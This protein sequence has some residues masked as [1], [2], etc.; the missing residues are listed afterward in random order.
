M[1]HTVLAIDQGTSSTK[2]MVV[3]PERDVLGSA[4]AD[5]RPR[6]GSDGSVEVDPEGMLRSVLDAGRQAVAR[7]GEPRIDAI[8][9]ANQGE[10]VLAWDPA[11]GRPLTPA[12]SWSDRRAASIC[13]EL[14]GMADE[15]RRITGL[16][17]DPYFA[18][19]KM[20]WIR[21]HLTRDGVVTT[22]DAWLVDRL[23]G[24]FV[25]DAATAG[26]TQLLDLDEVAWSPTA[27][28]AFG[29]AG[30][31]L[32]R[33][34]DT[35]TPVGE[36]A[37][38]GAR[39][40]VT[41]L[42][43]DQQA[44][45]LGAGATRP[46][47]AKCT[48]GTGAFLVTPTGSTAHRP[49]TDLA[50]CVAW[51]RAGRTRY[52]LDGQV[53]SAGSVV[54]WLVDNGVLGAATELDAVGG[55]VPDRAGVTFVPNADGPLGRLVG[56]AGD[57]Q[58]G[59]VVRAVVE[60]IAVQVVL[61]AEAVGAEV[62]RPLDHV[63]ADGGLSRS[64]L[65]MQAQA[66]LLQQPVAVAAVADGT[67]LGIAAAARLGLD[68]GLDLDHGGPPWQPAATYEP[69]ISAAAAG[70]RVAAYRTALAAS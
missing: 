20:T 3:G 39:A 66:D 60:A 37:A 68:A 22:T 1:T 18:A 31:R 2:A 4:A 12:I 36:T 59:H 55:T 32:P 10:T 63:R 62:G 23:T 58:P 16:P 50:S 40:P 54:Q 19:P 5:A 44:A 24:E 8:G 43:P 13:A 30:E 56:A 15:L 47:R 7:A 27:V 52:C 64:R 57:T 49:T 65:L 69:R 14:R 9:L 48:Y 28:D 42:L 46:G 38:F 25:T 41:A 67:A 45:L 6:Y 17:L 34:V 11:T 61:I 53:Q 35:M 29:L 33:I 51:R 26:R 21:R 70:E